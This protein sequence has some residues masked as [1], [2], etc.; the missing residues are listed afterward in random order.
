[1]T[2]GTTMAALVHKGVRKQQ[3]YDFLT[4]KTYLLNHLPQICSYGAFCLFHEQKHF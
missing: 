4:I 2:R 3:I 1:M